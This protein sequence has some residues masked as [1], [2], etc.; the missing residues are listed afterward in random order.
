M[1]A[2]EDKAAKRDSLPMRKNAT[3]AEHSESSRGGLS[4]MPKASVTPRNVLKDLAVL[5]S[6]EH[7][8]HS[9]GIVRHL[10]RRGARVSIVA[11]SKE[12]LACK[13]KYCE[14]VLLASGTTAEALTEATLDAA[15]RRRF[16]V[17]IPV[18]YAMTK[19][20]G[21]RRSEL[22][23]HTRLELAE[24][25][26]IEMAADKTRMTKL[27]ERIGV[28]VPKT[29]CL[30][31]VRGRTEKMAFPVV[32]KPGK[33]LPGRPP[34]HYA[35]DAE[36]LEKILAE[37]TEANGT[38]GDGLIV[39]EFIPGEGYGF[40]ATYQNGE[41][42]RVFMHK[43]VREYPASGGVSTCA[44]SFY[45][46]ELELCGRKMLD[47]LCW[48]GVAMVEFR[49]DSR[50]GKFKLMEVNPKFWG[51][52]DLALAAG[53]D[54]P[55]DLCRMAAGGDL[56]FTSEYK[57]GLRFHWPL[58]GHGELFHL[59]TRPASCV[60]MIVDFLNP[61]VK[62]NVWLSDVRPNLEELRGLAAQLSRAGRG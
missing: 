17:V 1:I 46:A 22:P 15:N 27:A 62:S 55:G 21:R 6:D 4:K 48:H 51:S 23:A 28:A 30:E 60:A 61:R 33:E 58:S 20:L 56:R 19:V 54:F 11:A 12:S 35:R 2:K 50:D 36:E 13:S 59:W 47:A 37:K 29:F 26:T 10:G 57:R 14:E 25:E 5:I 31:E 44:E 32:I 49:R 43:R 34:V 39:Q 42:K 45:D 16:D 52:L 18:S 53:A 40:F 9:L 8:K 3:A 41:C 7:Y 38:S 24:S